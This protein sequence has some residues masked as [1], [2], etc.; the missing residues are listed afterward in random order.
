VRNMRSIGVDLAPYIRKGSLRVVSVRPASLGLEMHL[1]TMHK[2]IDE[3]DPT[4]VIVDPITNLIGV[5]S[6]AEAMSMLTRLIDFL[7][8]RGT[9]ALFTS[10]T[11]TGA[12][13]EHTD[14]GISSLIDTW[15]MLEMIRS[16]GERNRTINIIKSRGMP[17][18]NQTSE[19]VLGGNGMQ[20]LDTYLGPTGVVTGSARMT[21]EATDQ[22]T[23]LLQS[24]ELERKQMLRESRRKAF[25]A[26]RSA[27]EEE[28]ATEDAELARSIEVTQAETERRRADRAE[29]GKS[30]RAFANNASKRKPKR[31][32]GGR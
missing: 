26:R 17:H 28:F 25:E 27:L 24:N 32:D 18:S 8:T 5:A 14:V 21:Q 20:I 15:L 6:K 12:D 23:A 19:Y 4:V 22:A 3:F 2:H 16:G 31:K 13:L 30:R 9:T 10:L 11:T 29:M 7:K 1:V